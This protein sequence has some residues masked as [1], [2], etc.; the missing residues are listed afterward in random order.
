L[1]VKSTRLFSK[2]LNR[3]I[4]GDG[5]W[6][7]YAD[8][9]KGSA[10]GETDGVSIYN[11]FYFRLFVFALLYL[12]LGTWQHRWMWRWLQFLLYGGIF[13]K[14]T[15]KTLSHGC[16]NQNEHYELNQRLDW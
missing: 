11:A 15:I 8:V 4:W 1:F 5:F 16:Q 14:G 6:S 9:T 13:G 7:V 3:A 10:V 12:Y 2:A